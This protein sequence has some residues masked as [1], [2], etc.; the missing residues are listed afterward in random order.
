MAQT[1]TSSIN[2]MG[3]SGYGYLITST[4]NYSDCYRVSYTIGFHNS[5]HFW[6]GSDYVYGYVGA[7]GQSQQSGSFSTN[8]NVSA[9]NHTI[10]TGSFLWNKGTSAASK[11]V[12]GKVTFNGSSGTTTQSFTIP[13]L[14]KYILTLDPSPGTGGGSITGY[15]N[16]VYSTTGY[17]ATR[18]GY[19]FNGWSGGTSWTA[20][21]NAT[22]TSLW[23]INSYTLSLSANGGVAGSV[24]SLSADYGN[25]ITLPSNIEDVPSRVNYNLLGWSTDP[26]ATTA[27]YAVGGVYPSIVADVMLYAVWE[28]A[29]IAPTPTVLTATRCNSSGEEDDEGTY[30]TI[31]YSFYSAS[32]GSNISNSTNVLIQYKLSTDTVYNDFA[33]FTITGEYSE[34]S[35][36]SENR[37]S[38]QVI[39]AIDS[40]YNIKLT[41]TDSSTTGSGSSTISTFISTTY[42]PLDISGDGKSFGI[43]TVAE[44]APSGQ[45]STWAGLFKLNLPLKVLQPASFNNTTIFNSSVKVN[46]VIEGIYPIGAIYISI[47]N[48]NP[49][50]FFGGTWEQIKDTFLLAAGST[51]TAG[52]T[53]G[54][55][56][57]T[58]T[59]E[60]MPE[61]NH[62]SVKGY[63][64]SY[65]PD[66]YGGSTAAYGACSGSSADG[67]NALSSSFVGGGQAHNNM[68]PYLAVYMW[69]RTA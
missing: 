61:H 42:F 69:K 41:L 6:K 17:T 50:A 62:T 33:N 11:N 10:R 51:Y 48:T 20:N 45:E 44:N 2:F 29:Y 1:N 7:T 37:F 63:S 26:N 9:G 34:N 25:N 47:N 40:K 23:K 13:A 32:N 28:I 15:Y 35:P 16:K 67:S 4:T 43:G 49:S 56:T 39:F 57:H 54:E 19:T 65:V 53:G 36:Y 52:A 8:S 60:E 5:S 30:A 21:G 27:T 59:T 64:S 68:P 3:Y 18:A 24:A 12:T 46:G 31:G 55:A 58:L 66:Y 14:S 22:W 38:N